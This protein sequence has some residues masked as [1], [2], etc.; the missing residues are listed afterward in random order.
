MINLQISLNVF[1]TASDV[2]VS[3]AREKHVELIV[4]RGA[5]SVCCFDETV[6]LHQGIHF[7]ANGD[8]V[9]SPTIDFFNGVNSL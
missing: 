3:P 5:V 7:I 2:A 8:H 6:V 1:L 4:I 9:I